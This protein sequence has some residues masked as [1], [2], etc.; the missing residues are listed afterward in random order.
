MFELAVMAGMSVVVVVV[1]VV[2]VSGSGQWIPDAGYR[3]VS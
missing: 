2:F 1:V 3:R